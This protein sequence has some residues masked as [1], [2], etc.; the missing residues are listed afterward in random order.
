M[1]LPLTCTQVL[2]IELRSSF[3]HTLTLLNRL[4]SSLSSEVSQVEPTLIS[5]KAPKKESRVASGN[6]WM[7]WAIADLMR[8]KIV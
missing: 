5:S 3:F 8:G 6:T 7:R 1:L 4:S 2:G